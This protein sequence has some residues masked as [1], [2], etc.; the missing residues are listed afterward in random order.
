MNITQEVTMNLKRSILGI[1]TLLLVVGIFSCSEDKS[2]PSYASCKVADEK[3][4]Q[5]TV[6]WL[7]DGGILM[8]QI[9]TEECYSELGFSEDDDLTKAQ[10]EWVDACVGFKVLP[11]LEPCIEKSGICGDASMAKCIIHFDEECD[12]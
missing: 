7:A 3:W 2:S 1:F 8:F 6:D 12:E 10:E 9:F 5:C 4:T 11:K